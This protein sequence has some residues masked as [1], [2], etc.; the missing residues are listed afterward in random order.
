LLHA[1]IA[2]VVGAL[3]LL[4]TTLV[5]GVN[6]LNACCG[7]WFF[8]GGLVAAYTWSRLQGGRSSFFFG[9]LSGVL[10]GVFFAISLVVFSGL[11]AGGYATVAGQALAKSEIFK[12]F[13]DDGLTAEQ[14]LDIT[15][16][17]IENSKDMAGAEREQRLSELQTAAKN[18]AAARQDPAKNAQ[19]EDAMAMFNGFVHKIKGGDA[20][21]L[22][23]I[24]IALSS[25]IGILGGA[26]AT[27]GGF[28]GGLMFG[29]ETPGTGQATPE[30]AAA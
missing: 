28:V 8:A 6:A 23:W 24:A 22:V 29:S 9:L 20:S 26:I 2:G 25:F 19:I 10:A 1:L 16:A 27:V 15:R 12:D 3:F 14:L 13:P 18:L 30:P 7:F 21:F 11:M 17:I 5:P 4:V